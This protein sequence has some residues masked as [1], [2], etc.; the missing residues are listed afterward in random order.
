MHTELP[1]GPTDGLSTE[2]KKLPKVGAAVDAAVVAGAEGT[3][4]VATP[5]EEAGVNG[6]A[7]MALTGKRVGA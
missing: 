5:T 2:L 4:P 7:T 1:K 6:L 3:A